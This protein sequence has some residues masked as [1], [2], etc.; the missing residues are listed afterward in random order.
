M[1]KRS[2]KLGFYFTLVVFA[3]MSASMLLI[4]PIMALTASRGYFAGM[5]IMATFVVLYLLE[6]GGRR[7]YIRHCR[8]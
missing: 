3:I 2:F 4:S 8:P 5:D 7:Y 6:H 1:K